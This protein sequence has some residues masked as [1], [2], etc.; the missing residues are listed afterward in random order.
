MKSYD[1]YDENIFANETL[2]GWYIDRLYYDFFSAYKSPVLSVVGLYNDT[3]TRSTE[4]MGG[5]VTDY[6]N[7][8]K[9]LTDAAQADAYYGSQLGVN[10]ANV[11]YTRIKNANFLL[12]KI[13][14]KGQALSDDFKK[15][16][17][18]QM[19]F[20]RGLQYFELMR[21]YG[22][23][24]IVT[25][26]ENASAL[27]SSI[28]HPRATTSEL[29]TQIISDFD[30]AAA[31]L[32]AAWGATD[33]GR[34]TSGAAL[35]MKS[36]VLL[37]YASPLFNKDW[38]NTGSDRWQKALD[39]GLAAET[40]LTAA[41]KGLY[42]KTAKEWSDM[43][44]INDTK[45]ND[46]E[47]IIIRLL[48][49]SVA[50]S[51]VENN[52]WERS[53]RVVKQTGAGGV[54]A[55]KEMIDL[56]P[57][58]DGSRPTIANGYDSLHFF[59]NRD[60][61][62]YRT[63]AF[64]GSRWPLKEAGNDTIWLYRWL[65]T[66]NKQT[67]S[68]GNQVSSPAIV[69]KMSNLTGAST[70]AGLAY[71]GT[72]IFEYRYAELLLNIAECY[73]AKGDV[74]NAVIYLGKIRERVGIPSA[75]NFGLGTPAGKYAAIEACLYERRVELAYEGKRFWDA[76]R[77][78]LYDGGTPLGENTCVKLGI[79]PINGTARTG[80]LWQYKTVLSNTADPLLGTR[81]AI[82]CDPD[83][84]N[85]TTQLNN[86]KTFFDNNLQVVSTDQPMDKDASNN[87]L[88][89]NFRSNYYISGLTAT[90]LSN[91]P[92]LKQTIG[93]KDYNNAAGTFD[94]RE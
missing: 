14:E 16:A 28:K 47:A 56:F 62:F 51:G 91:N 40:A 64:S 75:N 36:R 53:I 52:G 86:L 34:F 71:S 44:Y 78:L 87:P 82:L 48:S 68:D 17:R 59:L 88:S 15:K 93:W 79:N 94:Y 69:R 61:R 76:Q 25:T 81:T 84:A 38:D 32:P 67:Y 39:A 9:Q 35:A 77:W 92:W 54:S 1:K 4:E 5:T 46:K 41:G 50:S 26:T 24:P 58:A 70:A 90:I 60:P 42:G 3:R 31:L 57:L 37:A 85:F 33:Y 8:Q 6:T 80:R 29:V 21:V 2:T 30:S 18:G 7:P 55:P 89:I 63:F 11:P 43:W 23:V 19:L 45:L 66:G 13:G 20:M 12:E 83:A 49:N 73:A 65:S 74:G 72:D 22:G 27:D 10:P